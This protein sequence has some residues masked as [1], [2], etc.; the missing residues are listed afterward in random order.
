M[1]LILVPL[2]GALNIFSVLLLVDDREAIHNA[3]QV[4]VSSHFLERAN[5]ALHELQKE[6]GASAGLLGGDK[7]FR[8]TVDGQRPQTDMA[9]E[10]FARLQQEESESLPQAL[11]TLYAEFNDLLKSRK[12]LH[13][14]IDSSAVE[15]AEAIAYY[16][17][18]NAILLKAGP[19]VVVANN[20]A[21]LSPSL[22]ALHQ[23]LEMKERAGIERATVSA[24]LGAREITDA[25]LMR[26]ASLRDLQQQYLVQFRAYA[27]SALAAEIDAL[28]NREVTTSVEAIRAQV[29]SRNPQTPASTWFKLA[30]ERI[31][32]LKQGE[33]LIAQRIRGQAEVLRSVASDHFN[34][35]VLI[36]LVLL[37]V[38]SGVATVFVKSLSRVEKGLIQ[39]AATLGQAAQNRDLSLRVQYAGQDEVG[40]VAAAFNRMMTDFS[41]LIEHI[42]AVSNQLAAAAE[43]TAAT[44]AV[45]ATE[46]QSQ[47]TETL[48][49]TA[50]IEEMSASVTEV[51]QQVQAVSRSVQEVRQESQS[52][53]TA[54]GDS[55]QDIQQLSTEIARINE[56]I[57]QLSESSGRISEV[58]NVIRTIAGQTNL[59]ALNAAI[60][61]ARAGEAGRG[62]A[63]VADEVRALAQRTQESTVEIEEMVSLLQSS[64]SSASSMI[65]SSQQVVGR[66]VNLSG[67]V[68]ESLHSIFDA[69]EHIQSLTAQIAA[70]TQ[71]QAAASSE[72]ARSAAGIGGSAEVAVEHGQQI[73]R[74]SEELSRLAT[75]LN[76]SASTFRAA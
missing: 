49:V 55:V 62:F 35:S 5:N 54:V 21:A 52:A 15:P 3:E 53:E 28:L 36:N 73:A 26:V 11:K 56:G 33:D 76:Q 40:Q 1:S 27:P 19:R 74:V 68:S 37:I 31:N 39:L 38:I 16:T 48:S 70:T 60:E 18:L 75:E 66:S 22:I 63:V 9:L 4:L 17:A 64:V 72:V 58:M 34:R 71:Q 32:L 13:Q 57:L 23:F 47:L 61:A 30:T 44:T 7:G 20:D 42:R 41:R 25:A 24:A 50:A 10:A 6:R 46:L 69:I 67:R 29:L 2:I 65:G 8:S 14:R 45:S 51:S 12:N 59:L 43:E